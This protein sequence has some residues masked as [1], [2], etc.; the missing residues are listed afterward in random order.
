MLVSSDHLTRF[1]SAKAL[2]ARMEEESARQQRRTGAGKQNEP[3][4]SQQPPTNIFLMKSKF[5]QQQ[6]QQQQQQANNG[7]NTRRSLAFGMGLG[8]TTQPSSTT[9]KSIPVNTRKRLTMGGPISTDKDAK[10]NN[11]RPANLTIKTI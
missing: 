1:Q 2:F 4:S 7:V 11:N 10:V 3:N 5:E 9:P 8:N 6:Q